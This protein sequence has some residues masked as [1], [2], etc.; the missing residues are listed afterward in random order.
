[1]TYLRS[2]LIAAIAGSLLFVASLSARSQTT[3]S[4]PATGEPK[5]LAPRDDAAPKKNNKLRIKS[6]SVANYD[7]PRGLFSLH[8]KVNFQDQDGKVNLYCDEALYNENDDTAACAGNLKVTD[9][10][11]II[12]GKH[13]NA[14]FAAETI[15]IE[16]DVTIVT[17]K[18]PKEKPK[19]GEAKAE[20]KRVTTITCDKI[21]YT[22][23]EGKRRAVATGT[24]TAKQKDK[25][26]LAQRA[27]YDL[28]KDTI[29]VGDKITI[30]MDNGNKFECTGAV[31][32]VADD[33]VAMQN[34]TGFVL[35]DKAKGGGGAKPEAGTKPPG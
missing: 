34:I 22:Y 14:D 2:S 25:T 10:D 12:T 13:M 23:T 3:G 20:Q 35:S 4:V 15:V 5:K 19:E 28:E 7:I 1:M 17:T 16:G 8:G 18:G 29:T 11:N 27:D 26:V 21:V 32:G 30:T 31:I 33:T 6:A 24:I 9:P